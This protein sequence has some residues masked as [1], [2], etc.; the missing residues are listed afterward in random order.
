MECRDAVNSFG[1]L[2]AVI[3]PEAVPGGLKP[4]EMHFRR[5]FKIL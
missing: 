2:F 1:C 4:F 3:R 5:L